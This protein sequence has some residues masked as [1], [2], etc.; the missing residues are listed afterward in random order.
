VSSLSHWP[1]GWSRPGNGWPV[2]TVP[3]ARARRPRAEPPATISTPLPAVR[4]ARAGPLAAAR[5]AG[6]DTAR[7]VGRGCCRSRAEGQPGQPVSTKT[8]LRRSVRQARAVGRR[9]GPPPS[10]A[11]F[12]RP[13]AEA[14]TGKEANT[15][16]SSSRAVGLGRYLARHGFA[17][18]LVNPAWLDHDAGHQVI[19]VLHEPGETT[20]LYC[21]DPAPRLPVRGQVQPRHP[22][23]CDHRRDR[24]RTQPAP[25]W[26][27]PM[28]ARPATGRRRTREGRQ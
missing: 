18:S 16:T 28:R 24:R 2:R 1:S 23:R 4:Q 11:P 19:R 10:P 13:A 21:L 20:F 6:L 25:A 22:G 8:G 9:P 3:R 14:P 26:S 27:A 7:G 17:P 15:V 5:R 12:G